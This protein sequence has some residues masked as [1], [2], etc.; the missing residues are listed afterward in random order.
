[1]RRT[2]N[3]KTNVIKLRHDG[4]TYKEIS[5]A[6]GFSMSF[7]QAVCTEHNLTGHYGTKKK[8]D[9]LKKY[10]QQG[11][12]T[13]ET[14]L[15]FGIPRSVV[16]RACKGVQRPKREYNNQWSKDS[17]ERYAINTINEKLI[18]FAYAGNYTGSSGA[19]D[20][21]CKTCGDIFTQPFISIRQGCKVICRNCRKTAKEKTKE[22]AK[23]IRLAEMYRRQSEKDTDLFMRTLQVE[24]DVCGKIFTTKDTNRKCCSSACSKIRANKISS[25]RKDKRITKNKLIDKGITAKRL[26]NRDGGVCWICG[27]KCDLND[28]V[29]KDNV[30]ICGDYYPSVDHVVAVCDGGEDSWE[31]VRL[32]HRICNSMRYYNKVTP[33]L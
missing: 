29:V 17:Q 15:Y 19:V 22:T 28:Y 24:C 1:M 10:M 12:T 14:A 27:G 25:Q 32:A 13:E 21:Q 8:Y 7:V 5:E 11:H 31:N 6:L 9:E 20:I 16:C 26:Y 2:D 3:D 23:A 18:G 4:L 33:S 30:I